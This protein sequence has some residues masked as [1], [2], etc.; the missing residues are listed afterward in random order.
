MADPWPTNYGPD[1][2]PQAQIQR[3]GDNVRSLSE[4]VA[5]LERLCHWQ[6]GQLQ[7]LEAKVSKSE[8]PP[9]SGVPEAEAPGPYTWGD[10][11]KASFRE[12]HASLLAPPVAAL[13]WEASALKLEALSLEEQIDAAWKAN[14]G[15]LVG[16]STT[17]VN[18][19]HENGNVIVRIVLPDENATPP[20]PIASEP[21][22]AEKDQ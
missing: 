7:K 8:E 2:D 4:R 19:L 9:A 5:E 11:A 20:S 6:G 13:S 15:G 14:L 22:D 21:K 10:G 17:F 18:R 3:H 16:R 12:T 1:P